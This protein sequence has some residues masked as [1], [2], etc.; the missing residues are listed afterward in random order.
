MQGVQICFGLLTVSVQA[1]KNT[2]LDAERRERNDLTG[3]PKLDGDLG[4]LRGIY[5]G[6]TCK[7]MSAIL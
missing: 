5:S 4:H 6:L 3:G 7:L 1:V 2:S